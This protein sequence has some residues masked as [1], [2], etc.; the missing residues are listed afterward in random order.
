MSLKLKALVAGYDADFE[1]VC[2]IV[3]GV[4]EKAGTVTVSPVIH[5][6]VTVDAKNLK[7]FTVPQHPRVKEREDMA[8][9]MLAKDKAS[10]KAE[11]KAEKG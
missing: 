8:K 7:E 11:A 4:D 6:A 2:G 3:T 9:D 5:G 1:P 10:A